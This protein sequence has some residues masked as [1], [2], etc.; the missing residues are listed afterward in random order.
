VNNYRL[1]NV[2]HQGRL[3]DQQFYASDRFAVAETV[4]SP[5]YFE[6]WRGWLDLD[7]TLDQCCFGSHAFSLQDYPISHPTGE[8][9]LNRYLS[10]S[11]GDY[12]VKS[13]IGHHCGEYLLR[14]FNFSHVQIGFRVN[15]ET[16][17]QAI[18]DVIESWSQRR[19]SQPVSFNDLANPMSI[20]VRTTRTYWRLRTT[21]LASRDC[22][23][24]NVLPAAP[25][26]NPVP[27]PSLLK[28]QPQS[29]GGG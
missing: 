27:P 26:Y 2:T 15:N 5:H 12:Q 16:P 21:A 20:E 13:F 6:M 22:R 9:V 1:V 19:R 25:A 7:C 17:V 4:V 18:T 24:S 14:R 8:G 10:R 23:L 29:R 11:C 28:F 3:L